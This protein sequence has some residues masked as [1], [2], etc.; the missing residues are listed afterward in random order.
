MELLDVINYQQPMA[1]GLVEPSQ[2]FQERRLAVRAVALDL[3]GRVYMVSARR[4]T[5]YLKL[6]GGGVDPGENLAAALH[7][8]V[9]EELGYEIAIGQRIGRIVEFEPDLR[10]RQDSI[11]FLT[12]ITG[13][14][15]R[16]N[17]TADE[18]EHS[19]KPATFDSLEA[20]IAAVRA[21]KAGG[22]NSSSITRRELAFLLAARRVL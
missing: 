22:H 8:E 13:G 3:Q 21:V 4:H 5:E 6:P 1:T 19:F 17:Y 18:I 11:A 14:H 16:P 7:R 20:A 12:T 10:F 15:G 2:R 9:T